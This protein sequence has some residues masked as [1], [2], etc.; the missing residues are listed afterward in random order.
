[1]ERQ[2][3]ERVEIWKGGE[4]VGRS[5]NPVRTVDVKVEDLPN[6]TCYDFVELELERHIVFKVLHQ[7][8]LTSIINGAGLRLFQEEE[9]PVDQVEP[10]FVAHGRNETIRG[11][12]TF[13]AIVLVHPRSEFDKALFVKKLP[14]IYKRFTLTI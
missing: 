12:P 7:E 1:M 2:E 10:V 9:E 8:P 6:L 5:L 11:V 14:E 4:F 13:T 3:Y